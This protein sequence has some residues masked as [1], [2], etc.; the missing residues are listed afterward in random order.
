MRERPGA[1]VLPSVEVEEAD[2]CKGA[3]FVDVFVILIKV[4]VVVLVE[5]E[6]PG[7]EEAKGRFLDLGGKGRELYLLLVLIPVGTLHDEPAGRCGAGVVEEV[8]AGESVVG[9]SV[10]LSGMTE[11][12]V[13]LAGSS[14]VTLLSSSVDSLSTDRVIDTLLGSFSTP[15]DD[16]SDEE[17]VVLVTLVIGVDIGL[18]ETMEADLEDNADFGAFVTPLFSSPSALDLFSVF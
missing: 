10:P 6:A 12:V 4:L 17:E 2:L 9:V 8:S 13:V 15:F 5:E 1:D 11:L 14:S 3:L 7:V 16:L 18:A